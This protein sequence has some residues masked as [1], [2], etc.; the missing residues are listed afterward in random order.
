MKATSRRSFLKTSLAGSAACMLSPHSWSQVLGANDDIRVAV[1]GLNGRGGSH[2]DE[3]NKIK[4]VRLTALCDVDLDVLDRCA[5]N[6]A[7]VKAIL[8]ILRQG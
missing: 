1:V 7:G 2:I 3:F 6:L 4:G 5:R 8:A